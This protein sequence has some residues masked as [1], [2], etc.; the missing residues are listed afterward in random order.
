MVSVRDARVIELPRIPDPRGSL[1]VIEGGRHIPFDIKRI[2]YLYDVPGGEMRAGHANRDLQ[3]IIIAA[4][5]SF[6]VTID[7]GFERATFELKR[8]YYGLYV[9]GM[10]WR[11]ITDF[12]SG[13]VCVVLA[14]DFYDENDYYRSYPEYQSVMATMRKAS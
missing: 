12:S 2:F 4:S 11:E 1:T 7:D 13:A 14:S 3:Q 5:G 9:P 8:S 10:L 6:A